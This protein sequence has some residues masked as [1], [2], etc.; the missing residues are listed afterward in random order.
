[1]EKTHKRTFIWY[2][3]LVPVLTVR[4][5]FVEKWSRSKVKIFLH[6]HIE[7][8]SRDVSYI[9]LMM[10]YISASRSRRTKPPRQNIPT[11]RIK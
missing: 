7:F 10:S 9:G 1:M 5:V 2:I 3:Q 4:E 8:C 6:G 11:G